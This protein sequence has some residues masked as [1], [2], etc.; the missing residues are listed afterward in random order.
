MFTKILVVCVGNIC[1]S[2]MAEA[3]LIEEFR[4]KEKNNHNISSAGLNALIG[5]HPDDTAIELMLEKGID[6]SKYFAIQINEKI[7]KESD[8]I[9]VMETGH[10]EAIT[11]K[12]PSSKG[13]V[14]KLG[15]WSGF[16]IKDPYQQPREA[17]EESL[18]L[19]EQG[20]ADWI[21][22]L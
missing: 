17:F 4:K 10:I 19:I 9:L 3:L 5:H 13:K 7:I 12:M 2:P 8:L 15:Q 20:V 6:I 18:E 22:R 16:E 1:R 14:F 11:A 21:E